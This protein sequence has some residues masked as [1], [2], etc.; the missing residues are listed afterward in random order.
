MQSPGRFAAQEHLVD[1]DHQRAGIEPLGHPGLE[2]AGAV[3]LLVE[4]ARAERLGVRGELVAGPPGLDRP[5]GRLSGKYAALDGAVA[6]LDS[7]GVEESGLVAEQR[8]ARENQFR[9]RLQAARRDR[10][11]ALADA[12]SAFQ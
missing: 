6:A 1:A 2:V 3:E 9:Q 10:A 8:A 5:R 4:P 7:R 11:G 12:L